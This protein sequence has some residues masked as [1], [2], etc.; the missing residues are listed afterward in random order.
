M[1]SLY[2]SLARKIKAKYPNI[3]PKNIPCKVQTASEAVRALESQLPGFKTFIRRKGHYKIV[4]GDNVMDDS[5]SL[6]GKEMS[7]SFAETHF[8][9]MPIAAGAGGKAGLLQTVLGAIILAVGIYT[10]NSTM[11]SMGAGMMLGGLV[12]MLTPVP[13]MPKEKGQDD[14]PSY[15]FNGSVNI[16]D[17]GVTIPVAYGE[18]F[19][20]SVVV[21]FG[22]K[23]EAYA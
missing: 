19:V 23:V 10:E 18:T 5:K 7:M 6:N 13:P 1:I 3:D 8:H 14:T 9:F 4:R 22:I 2:G 17:P 21:S 15:L 16:E 20:G 11:I 12:T